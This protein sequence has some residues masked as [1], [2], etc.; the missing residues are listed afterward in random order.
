[1]LHQTLLCLLLTLASALGSV[2][3][4]RGLHADEEVLFVPS[5]ARLLADGSADVRVEAWVF[6]FES[7]PGLTPLLAN[8]LDI[9]LDTLAESDRER[10]YART[11]WFRVDSQNFKSLQIDVGGQR[12]DLPRTRH[13]GRSSAQLHIEA[14]A[15]GSSSKWLRFQVALPDAD[16]RSFRGDALMV[17]AQGLSVISDIDDTIKESQVRERRELLL[18]TFAREFVAV[19]GAA[20]RYQALAKPAQTRFHYVSSGPTQL[21]PLLAQFLRSQ[22]F[23]SGS[24]HLRESTSIANVIAG[25]GD[26]RAHKL[27][28]I[29]QLLADFPERQFLLVGDS[30][31]ADPEIYGEVA[32]AHPQQVVGIRIRDVSG[33]APESPRYLAAFDQ[34]PQALWQIYRDPA[35]LRGVDP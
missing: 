12:A 13:G 7:R 25:K 1:M 20:D 8:Y 27:A 35:A 23:P 34:L 18:N 9:D 17:P 2:A 3:E 21:Y 5:T 31:E 28:A 15:L 32:R 16:T 10:F 29:R 6:E 19:A 26:S 14:A 11:Q 24:M 4:A 30:G 22:H 33:D